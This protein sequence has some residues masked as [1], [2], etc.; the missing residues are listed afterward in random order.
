MVIADEAQRVKN[1]NDTSA[2]LKR[3]PRTRSWALT[4][5]PIEND[6]EEL[7]SIMEF[8]DYDPDAPPIR[9]HPGPALLRRH[10]QVQI[11]RRKADVLDDLP[12]KR[13]SKLTIELR[14]SQRASYDRAERDGIIYLKSLGAEVR[15]QHILELIAR[16]KQICN[17]DPETGES[18]KLDD[19]RDRIERLSAQGHKALVFSQYTNDAY[20][21]AAAAN[22]LREFSPI[23]LTGD[24]PMSE[25]AAVIDNFKTD[26]R[27]KALVISL[28]V[29]GLGLNL[30]EASYVFH[31]DRWW[32]PAVERQAED[33][34]HRMGQTAKVNVIK[35][36][37]SDT[38]EERIDEI[39]ERKQ[40]LFDHLIDDVSLDLSAR[41]SRDELLGLFGLG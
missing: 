35:Y 17:V 28:R 34:T 12:P 19:I 4:G 2:A 8:V 29:G 22:Q 9:Y 39:L 15:V 14:P 31:L 10:Q 11:R 7:A 6:E 32:N 41:L 38:I 33:R 24:T 27:H 23:T 18:S 13:E 20:G 25:R 16:L 5:T 1:R 37:C 3:L 30:Q 36:S 21:V 40:E 26:D